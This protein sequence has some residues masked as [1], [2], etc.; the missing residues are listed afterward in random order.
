M[1]SIPYHRYNFETDNP[2][3]MTSPRKFFIG[4]CGIGM[5]V[6]L[7]FFL[8][9]LKQENSPRTGYD[10]VQKLS[11]LVNSLKEQIRQESEDILRLKATIRELTDARPPQQDRD[12]RPPPKPSPWP[13]PIPVVVFAC[14]RAAAV[15]GIVKKLISLRPSKDLFPIIVSQDCDNIPVQ[16]AVAEFRNQV[17]YIKHKSAQQDNVV[18]PKAH[19]KYAA[20]Y[21]IAR[22]YK[23]ALN[24]VFNV[25]NHNTVILLE[26]DL[27][28]ATD[29]F[30]YFSATRYL[31]DRDPQLWCVSAW[32]DNGKSGVID[33]S[34]NSLLYRSDFFPGLGWMMTS[35]TWAELSPKWPAGFWDDWMR[36]PENRQGRQCIRPEVSRTKM[37]VYGKKG[38]S[39][40]QFYEKHVA[41]VI[42]N[43]VPVSFT[44]MDLDY[45]LNPNYDRQFNRLVYEKSQLVNI[46]DA[47]ASLLEMNYDSKGLRVEYTGNIDFIVKADKLLVMHDFKAGVPR[48]AY[49][50]V[51]TSFINGTRV[52]LVPDRKFV[53]D[54]DKTWVVPSK[55]GD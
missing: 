53:K 2:P 20:Y 23:L 48:T 26:D 55:F 14:S 18:V 8:G 1:P 29:F 19:K 32:N 37:T 34:A 51:V 11:S 42:L 4:V 52:F 13:E 50:G 6:W 21:Y 38:A 46:D 9:L 49:K 25:L 43:T 22:H 15:T 30:E 10:E 7:Y 12:P 17:V 45:L 31:L 27:D 3:T 41:K 40:G 54:Y 33:T 36:E 35:K 44:T 28:I 47:V 24:H 39:K 5:T 16:R